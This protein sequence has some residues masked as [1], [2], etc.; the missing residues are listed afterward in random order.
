MRPIILSDQMYPP[1]KNT[2]KP[3]Y[4]AQ[5]QR[6]APV[7]ASSQRQPFVS[8]LSS[9]SR[10]LS[11]RSRDISKGKDKPPMTF[12]KNSRPM[13]GAFGG[14]MN[15][16]NNRSVSGLSKYQKSTVSTN[17]RSNFTNVS[18]YQRAPANQFKKYLD[19]SSNVFWENSSTVR[20]MKILRFAKYSLCVL[21]LVL[22][23]SYFLV[24]RI[25][26]FPKDLCPPG[27]EC[28]VFVRCK[29]GYILDNNYCVIDP[30]I[31]N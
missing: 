6:P 15:P 1:K 12:S 18:R 4:P 17:Y 5:S 14:S 10:P 11:P 2:A 22:V 21:L 19:D 27:A 28:G 30:Q 26:A 13:T 24:G 20:N 16:V 31:K 7:N 25:K 9:Y 8:P 3:S 23:F 29:K